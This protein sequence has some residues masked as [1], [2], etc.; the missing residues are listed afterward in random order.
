MLLYCNMPLIKEIDDYRTT[1]SSPKSEGIATSTFND[2]GRRLV[3]GGP[4]LKESQAYPKDFGVGLAKLYQKH[5]EQIK[6]DA[7]VLM[8]GLRTDRHVSN[9]LELI[10]P[11]WEHVWED[12][13]LRPVLALLHC[14][15]VQRGG[16]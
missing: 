14:V 9:V 2:D 11:R 5:E 6:K 12:A 8:A 15:G 13:N 10:Q 4:Q 3:N 1:S 7:S 16:A